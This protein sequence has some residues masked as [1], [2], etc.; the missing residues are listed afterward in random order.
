VTLLALLRVFSLGPRDLCDEVGDYLDRGARGDE[1]GAALGG[2]APGGIGRV[3]A[4]HRLVQRALVFW[5][6]V[7]AVLTLFAWIG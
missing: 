5:L 3:R 4:A 7:I 6:M 1:V 2:A